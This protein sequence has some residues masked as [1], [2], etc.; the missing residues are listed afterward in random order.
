MI[1]GEHRR[2]S[3]ESGSFSPIVPFKDFLEHQG[4]GAWEIIA[5]YSMLD[6]TDADTVDSRLSNFSLGLNWYPSVQTRM[7]LNVLAPN[8]ENIGNDVAVAMR[9]QADF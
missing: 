6:L 8:L 2:Y 9:L 3:P 7:T 4:L 1:T 5:R